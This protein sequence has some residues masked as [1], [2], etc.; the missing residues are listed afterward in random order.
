MLKDEDLVYR[1]AC[2]ATLHREK[3]LSGRIAVATLLWLACT[4]ARI[5]LR[6]VLGVYSAAVFGLSFGVEL[7]I[8]T[9]MLSGAV[10][11]VGEAVKGNDCGLLCRFEYPSQYFSCVFSNLLFWVYNFI[12]NGIFALI[13]FCL[14]LYVGVYGTVSYISSLILLF[15]WIAVSFATV[16]RTSYYYIV[17]VGIYMFPSSAFGMLLKEN[18]IPLIRIMR[19][20]LRLF[21][22]ILSSL[23]IFTV[24][25][26]MAVISAAVIL[27]YKSEKHR[28]K[29]GD[30]F[31]FCDRIRK[32]SSVLTAIFL[33][34]RLP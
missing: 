11:T 33:C 3:H 2:G 28:G 4:A 32:P 15:T 24:P 21:P 20:F 31:H 7:F 30:A 12:S 19:L 29:I 5:W 23:M 34:R 10:T 13:Y 22:R 6:Q 18:K 1:V 9:P 8:L 26:N 27:H 16:I 17:S 14:K 25:E